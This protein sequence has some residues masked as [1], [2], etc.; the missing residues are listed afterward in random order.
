MEL[1]EGTAAC[2][3]LGER[4]QGLSQHLLPLLW[5]PLAVPRSLQGP[6][7][8]GKALAPPHWG[9]GTAV[10][11]PTCRLCHT[12]PL[13]SDSQQHGGTWA[14]APHKGILGVFLRLRGIS[15]EQG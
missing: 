3:A 2:P 12:C 8:A 7:R 6:G 10:T 11:T 13:I 5:A 1:R 15:K 9:C 4:G 14:D